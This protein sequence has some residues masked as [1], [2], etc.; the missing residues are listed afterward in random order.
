MTKFL[1]IFISLFLINGNVF[2]KNLN[3]GQYHLEHHYGSNVYSINNGQSGFFWKGNDNYT[4]W[5]QNQYKKWHKKCRKNHG[6]ICTYPFWYD[7]RDWND[8]AW[9][10]YW[11]SDTYKNVKKVNHKVNAFKNIYYSTKDLLTW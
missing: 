4:N 7:K 6:R 9:F 3:D 11:N 2:A 10:D 1:L 5:E 8:S